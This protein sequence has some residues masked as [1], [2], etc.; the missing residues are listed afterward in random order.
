MTKTISSNTGTKKFLSLMIVSVF[1][2]ISTISANAAVSPTTVDVT[3]QSEESLP[4]TANVDIAEVP[5]K[6]DVLF[7]FDLTGS[8]GGVLNT[9]KAK[10]DDIMNQLNTL[11]SDVNF[12]VI[13]F[14]D[15]NGN[16]SSYGYS[17]YYGSS[18]DF[19]YNLDSSVS[20]DITAV[21]T[22]INNLSY[23]GGSDG[24]ESYTRALYESYSDDSI[25]W[26][27]G[28]R[29]VV[30]MFG[31][32]IPHDNDLNEGVP[33]K[34]GTLSTGGDPG[35]D[36]TILTADDLD[37]QTVLAEMNSNNVVLIA[38]QKSGA[39]LDYW[40][41][42]ASLTG[43]TAF[44]ASLESLSTDIVNQVTGLLTEPVVTGLTL[45]PEVGYDMW[46]DNLMPM[47]YTGPTGVTVPFDYNLKVPVGTPDGV[48]NFVLSA[49]D[50]NMVNYGDIS[51][52][53]TVVNT[54]EA[55]IDVVPNTMNLNSKNNNGTVTGFIQL[56]AG[57]DV[58]DVNISTV[59]LLANGVEISAKMSPTAVG[60]HFGDGNLSLMVKFQK[61]SVVNALTGMT[62]TAM[63]TIKGELNDSTNFEGSELIN[64]VN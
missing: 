62:G 21:S 63:L 55:T 14:K 29:K 53:V 58:N 17:S 45:V 20:S 26:R 56:P 4:Q 34:T 28:A 36:V 59:K 46:I 7:A 47:E 13:S 6:A 41:H 19:P 1:L 15:Y 44:N 37:L 33:G 35:R 2:I 18:T 49:L 25:G 16:F 38:A 54:I 61:E 12:G 22:T 64:L 30:V 40:T 9:V 51:I 60:N 27:T 3:L 11:G 23:S 8:M 50:T 42:W 39:Y 31:D 5:P 32:N 43:G 48:Y 57:Y 24:P 10:A 52:T